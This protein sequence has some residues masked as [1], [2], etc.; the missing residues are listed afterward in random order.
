[1]SCTSGE[2]AQHKN[3]QAKRSALAAGNRNQ[4][5]RNNI[6]AISLTSTHSVLWIEYASVVQLLVHDYR[7][8]GAATVHVTTFREINCIFFTKHS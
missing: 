7:K 5:N 2:R 4:E 3:K 6:C 8:T 1:M